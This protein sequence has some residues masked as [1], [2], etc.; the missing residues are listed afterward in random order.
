MTTVDLPWKRPPLT[1]NDRG[2]TRFSPFRRVKAEALVMIRAAHLD[3]IGAACVTLHWRIPDR[4]RRDADNLGPTLKACQDA[5]VE[6]GVLPD[7]S[8]QHVPAATCRIHPPDGTPARMWLEL[9]T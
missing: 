7:D 2:H 9:T 4:R 6:A 8:W 5:L 3:P 1:G